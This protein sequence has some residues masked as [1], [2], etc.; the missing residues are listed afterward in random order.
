MSD[1]RFGV[2][3]V[4]YPDPDPVN[5]RGQNLDVNRNLLSLRSF[6]TSLKKNLFEVWFY[7]IFF[8]IFIHV[9]SPG[10]GAENPLGTKFWCQQEHLVTCCKFQKNLFEVWFYTIFFFM[11]FPGRGRQSPGD[12]ILMSTC[13]S[14]SCDQDRLNKL[15]FPHPIGNRDSIWNLASIS[16]VVSEEKMFKECGRWTDRRR[17]PTYPISSPMSLWLSWA[18][19]TVWSRS[20]LFAW[21]C[22]KSYDQYSCSFTINLTSTNPCHTYKQSEVEF[23]DK[24]QNLESSKS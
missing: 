2:S 10:A 8:M 5:S 12:K 4:N 14:W 19:N 23:P 20:L 16:P 17:R 7:T 24:L 1:C 15:S 11:I 13:Q 3:P 9:Y 6:A 22:L 18:K 21:T